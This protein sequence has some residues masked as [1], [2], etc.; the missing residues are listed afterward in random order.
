MKPVKLSLLAQ[1]LMRSGWRATVTVVGF[2]LL[3]LG[4]VL[5]FLPGPGLLVVIAGLAV[6]ATQFAWAERALARVKQRTANARE[7][8]R[9]R[10]GRDRPPSAA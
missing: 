5:L 9:A 4:L 1:I 2:G 10:M 6:L 3:G 8:A 7:A